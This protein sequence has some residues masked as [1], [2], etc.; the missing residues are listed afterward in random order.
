MVAMGLRIGG[1][2]DDDHAKCPKTVNGCVTS[3]MAMQISHRSSMQPAS[4][5]ALVASSAMTDIWPRSM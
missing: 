2:G 1:D 4:V 3:R 5:A